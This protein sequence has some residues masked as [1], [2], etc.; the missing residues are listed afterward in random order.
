MGKK[1][2]CDLK[3]YFRMGIIINLVSSVVLY[4]LILFV[5]GGISRLF[6]ADDYTVAFIVK[7]LPQYGWGFVLM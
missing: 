5:G 6:G 7:I 3:F 2:V 1:N 4:V